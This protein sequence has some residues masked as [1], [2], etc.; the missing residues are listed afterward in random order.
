MK[1]LLS[2]IFWIYSGWHVYYNRRYEMWNI[3]FLGG[4]RYIEKK[5]HEG[6]YWISRIVS[7]SPFIVSLIC[8]IKCGSFKTN[9]ECYEW[10]TGETV[11]NKKLNRH[12]SDTELLDYHAGKEVEMWLKKY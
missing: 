9:W 5:R 2:K 4:V 3:H 10:Y 11:W 7:N 12:L 6:H 1:N 8:F